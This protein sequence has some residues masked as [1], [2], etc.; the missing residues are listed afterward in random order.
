MK[1]SLNLILIIMLIAFNFSHA[2]QGKIV[3]TIKNAKSQKGAV[4]CCLH[5]KATDFPDKQDNAISC[6]KIEANKDNLTFTFVNV[7]PGTYAISAYHDENSD[8]KLNTNFLGIP[9]E[10]IG[11][12][13]N[14]MRA[15]G[16]P[17]FD[18]AKFTCDANTEKK[19]EINLK[20]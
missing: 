9:K 17:V 1:K 3:V 12:S 20:Y 11:V 13:N 14:K 7:K 18:D 4:W 5:N 15:M 16:S 19:L 6:Q 10:G 2:Q 8:G